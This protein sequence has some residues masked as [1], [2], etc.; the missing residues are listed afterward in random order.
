MRLLNQL[1]QKERQ[2]F[3]M[4]LF[5]SMCIARIGAASE[6]FFKFCLSFN[7]RFI[8]VWMNLL[9]ILWAGDLFHFILEYCTIQ[10]LSCSGLYIPSTRTVNVKFNRIWYRIWYYR[11]LTFNFEF[12]TR[13]QLL[14]TAINWTFHMNIYAIDD[15]FCTN[16]I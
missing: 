15:I 14:I 13:R 7:F 6:S 12:I 5:S 3:C 9:L 10:S 2:Y 11:Y 4:W 16:L 8:C 1:N